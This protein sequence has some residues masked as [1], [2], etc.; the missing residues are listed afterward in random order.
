MSSSVD[1]ERA[2]VRPLIATERNE[3]MPAWA[4][5]QAAL[6]YVTDRNG[7]SEIW[8]HRPDS[9]E[10]P[11]VTAREFPKHMTQWFVGPAISPDGG[12]VIYAR[13]G[14]N[15]TNARLWISAVAG[16]APVQLTND[17]S[18]FE[19]PGSWSPDGNWFVYL[20]NRNGKTAVY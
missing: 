14:A 6:I 10:R 2:R 20:A 5:K 4:A 19:L 13:I 17:T 1:L 18:T 15:S 7:A 12:R 16:G 8:L 11:V 9:P 3:M